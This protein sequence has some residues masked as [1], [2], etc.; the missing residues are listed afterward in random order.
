MKAMATINTLFL[1]VGLYLLFI[2]P[3]K[4]DLDVRIKYVSLDRAGLINEGKRIEVEWSFGVPNRNNVPRFIA[5]PALHA[6]AR[7]ASIF[8]ILA[9]VNVL[10]ACVIAFRERRLKTPQSD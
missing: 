5:A 7:N 2:Q 1:L 6:E 3:V 10:M 4:T 8:V 9:L